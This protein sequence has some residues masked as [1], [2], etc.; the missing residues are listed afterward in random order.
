MKGPPATVPLQ[1]QKKAHPRRPPA[2]QSVSLRHSPPATG[3]PLKAPTFHAPPTA[4]VDSPNATASNKANPP[5][6]VS[7]QDQSNKYSSGE[8]SDAGK[9]FESSNNNALQTNASFADRDDPPFFLRNSSSDD[10]PPEGHVPHDPNYQAQTSM[11]HR[12]GLTHLGIDGSSTEDFRGVIDDLTIANKKLKQK[13]KKYEKLYD[14][15]LQDEK[16]FEVRFHGLPDHKKKELEDTLRNF[17]AGLNDS[18]S[19]NSSSNLAIPHQPPPFE[20]RKTASSHASRFAESGYVSMSASGKNSISAPSNRASDRISSGDIDR[21]RMTK[22]QYSRQQQSIQSYLHDIPLGLLPKSHA[23]MTDKARKKLVVRRLEQIF[24]GKRSAP[25][26]H[27]QPIQQEEVAQSAAMA[28]RQAKEATGQQSKSEGHREARIM[29]VRA[30][31]EDITGQ[32]N[33]EPLKKLR[34]NLQVNEQDLAGFGSPDQRPTR[35]LDLDPFRAQVPAENMDYIRHLGFTPPNMST[36]EAPELGHG[37]LYLNLLINMAQLHTFNVTPEFVKDAVTEYSSKFELSHDGRK[38]RWKGGLDESKVSSGSSSEHF[39]GDSPYD[40]AIVSSGESPSKVVKPSHSGSGESSLDPERRARRLARAQKQK[41]QEKFTYTPIFFHKEESEGDDDYYGY[42]MDSSTTS[43]LQP[44]QPGDSSGLGSSAMRSSSSR[45]RRDN[46]PIIFYSNAKFCTDL[47]GDL[48]GLS[49]HDTD[50]YNGITSHPIGVPCSP[51][52]TQD[53]TKQPSLL[54]TTAMDIDGKEDSRTTSSYGDMEFSP[55]SLRND[56]GTESPDTIEFEASGLG[57]VQPDDNFS[58]KVRRS[59]TQAA[60]SANQTTR[61]KSQL[62]P[63]KILE[64][65]GQDS[66]PKAQASSSRQSQ[67]VIKEEILSASRKSLPSS[68]LP[69]ASFLP[70]DSTSSGDVDS[71]LDSDVSSNPSTT[72]S[73]ENRLTVAHIPNLSPVRTGNQAESSEEESLEEE[74]SVSDKS[75]DLLATARQMDPTTVRNSERDYDAAVVDRLAEMIPAGSSAATAGGGSGFQSPE[76][77]DIE[78]PAQPNRTTRKSTTSGSISSRATN[79]KRTRTRDL[80]VTNLQGSRGLKNQK[81]K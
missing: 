10:S 21:R 75:I 20:P 36:G 68:S 57:G 23:P 22:S 4:S 72:N 50:S 73:S 35:P 42:E 16:L 26:N 18:L 25:G 3:A 69:P 39:S 5:S 58:I 29:P 48:R 55:E 59:Q 33:S 62:Y 51:V 71:D 17:A 34:P 7:L 12:P 44:Q 66:S 1:S 70:F 45:R 11:P 31:D 13:L 6:S 64:A 19:S 53:S 74:D 8:S 77:P 49:T 2:H 27:P 41:E 54:N 79:R 32:F 14:R 46:G 38:I 81:T 80:S 9:W 40:S 15:H 78:T 37:W 60:S 67:T 61:H 56:N 76:D 28:D 65:L 47:S 63:I 24:A 43:F 30:D 52:A